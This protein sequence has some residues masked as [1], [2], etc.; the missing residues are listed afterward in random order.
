MKQYEIW[1]ADMPAPIG[2]RPV[3][4]LTR[5]PAYRYL[6]TCLVAEITTRIRHIAVELPLGRAEGLRRACVAN[7]DNL[8]SVPLRRLVR[9][10]GRLAPNRVPDLKR[11]LGHVLLWDEL[12]TP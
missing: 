7:F 10:A 9:R 11:A 2:R 12:L 5:T 4:L 3:L 8:H 1:W 6:T